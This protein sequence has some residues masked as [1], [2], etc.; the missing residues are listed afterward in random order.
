MSEQYEVLS[1][2][3]EIDPISPRGISPRVTDLVGK[4]IGLLCDSKIAARRIQ[5]VVEKE[6]KAR[7][8]T[9]KFAWWL[10]EAGVREYEIKATDK[11]LQ[12]WVKGVDTVILSV[13]D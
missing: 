9:A 2:W 10:P 6:L 12:N 1:P 11:K 13:G 8:P 3:A 4:T 5:V 7:F